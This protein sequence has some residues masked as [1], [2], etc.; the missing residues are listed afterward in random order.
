[1]LPKPTMTR[2]PANLTWCCG[3]LMADTLVR[4]KEALEKAAATAPASIPGA[5]SRQGG[6]R[7]RI[8][9]HLVKVSC[10]TV[11]SQFEERTKR[12]SL[13]VRSRANRCRDGKTLP[14]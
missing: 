9:R 1:M 4:R 8:I 2:R 6:K 12:P 5:G 7:L 11:P 3:E 13:F 14:P 10:V